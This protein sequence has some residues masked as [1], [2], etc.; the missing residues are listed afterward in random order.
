MKMKC[1]LPI[2]MAAV[3][4]GIGPAGAGADEGPIKIGAMFISSGK[5]GGYGINGCNAIKMAVEEINASG[6]ILG[7]KLEAVYGDTK[8]KPEVVAEL[9][10]KFLN[11]DKVDFLMG[12]TSSGLALALSEAARK[13]K[14]IL[15]VTQA[16]AGA[17]TGEKFNPY[18]FSTLS[19]AMMHARAGAYLMASKPYKKWMV[20]APDYN[21]GHE[22]WQFFKD[23]LKELRPDVEFVGEAWPKLMAE[24]YAPFV[25]EVLEKKPDAVWCPLWGDDAVRFI[26][27]G[28]PEKLFDNVKFA[29]SCGAAL[30]VLIPVGKDM[31]EG[32]YMSSR[33][34]FTTPDTD[35]NR[36]FA[37]S[38]KEKYGE[39][40]DYMAGETYSGVY[41]LKA[42]IERAGST[43]SDKII[44]AV[45]AHP[46]A[47]DTPEGW[48]IMR[49][50]DHQ[51][52]E[53][54]IWGET[55]F[56]D[57]YEFPVLKNII[58][59]QAEQIGRSPSE[60]KK[61]MDIRGQAPK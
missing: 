59:I 33:Y 17:L 40:P 20:V 49:K 25:K 42:A 28:L 27:Q 4:L 16:A 55:F 30:E 61:V 15:V 29:M 48:K 46:F 37:K 21:F 41:F 50:E 8:L 44:A 13:N 22:S 11:E 56:S 1:L 12:P 60:L 24:D 10:E 43:D 18:L 52:V 57:E 7:R 47:W 51:A 35:E 36:R 31:P 53:D 6:G 3:A 45:E 58:S 14:K 23:K 26:K 39:Y 5:L 38:Y 54:V 2:L 34:L 9:V 19:N 32:L